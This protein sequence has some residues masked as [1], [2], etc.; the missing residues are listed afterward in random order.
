[1][2]FFS[3]FSLNNE[4]YL[5]KS[6]INT[7]EYSICGFSY[8][9]IKA[10]EHVKQQLE[11]SS[12]VDTLQL[13]SP[14]FFQTKNEKFKRLQLLSYSKNTDQYIRQFID[15]CFS[16]HEKKI[17]ELINSKKEELEELLKYEWDLQELKNI[18]QKGVKIEVYLGS[19]DKI[20][21][22]CGAREFFLQIAT[23]TYIKS[24]NHFL[25][26]N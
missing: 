22:V 7:S 13:F 15:L 16:P 10:L 24:A 19:E 18:S 21:D 23:V 6:F 2:K 4:M 5:F 14:A 3:G 25:Q 26:I 17:V 9:S 1:M 20:I 11:C 12:R 8:G